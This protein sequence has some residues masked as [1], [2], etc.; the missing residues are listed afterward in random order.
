MKLGQR[1]LPLRIKSGYGT[2]EL[3]MAAVEAMLQLYLL[4]Y[5]T[6]VVGLRPDWAGYALALAV[7]WDAIT[8][9]VMGVV[10]DRTRSPWGRRRPYIFVGCF[11]MAAS[12]MALFNPP[13]VASQGGKFAYLLG[14]YI[15]LNT[16]Y[17]LVAVP[18][19]TLGKE[20][21]FDRNERTELF[22]WRLL[23]RNG[24]L[25]AG[26][27][28]PGFLLTELQALQ[29]DN[30]EAASRA[31][32]SW[33]IALT[34]IASALITVLAI[35]RY[36]GANH[37][38]DE[39]PRD[40]AKLWVHL[41]GLFVDL[42]N[43]GRNPVFAPMVL[44]YVIA[45][46]GR[47]LNSS[48]ALYYYKFR[49]LLTE[50]QIV[51]DILAL[52]AVVVSASILF[53]VF[54]SSRLGKRWPAFFGF[55]MLG[56]ITVIIYPLLPPGKLWPAMVFASTLSG[57]MVG[58]IVIFESMIADIVDYDELKTGEHREG[59]YFG[60]WTMA[61]KFARAFGLAL[62]GQLLDAIGF[63]EGLDA[64]P[65]EIGF[66]LSMI[67]GPLVGGIFILA[68]LVFLAVPFSD[69]KH[70]RIQRLLEKRRRMRAQRAAKA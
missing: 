46:V 38:P 64:Y 15:L 63:R 44:A 26:V 23:F 59:L 1:G 10:S 9:P 66:R 69:A 3:G 18:H 30:A 25:L 50:D 13:T 42:F 27:L 35:R 19:A 8:D 60:C 53:W 43:V 41:K 61:T 29:A 33:W 37:R 12:F 28:A 55:F 56:I 70:K 51:F 47:T 20:L 54:I 40:E 58:C 39:E 36:D 5:Y 65:P 45:F 49:L 57:F 11:L 17:T 16:S 32:A 21:S 48:L 52:F 34:I 22:G 67:F 14:T 6:Q 68:A 2:A 62:S 31:Q 7:I 4:E 24:G